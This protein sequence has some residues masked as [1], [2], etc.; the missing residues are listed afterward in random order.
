VESPVL[1]GGTH[2]AIRDWQ[3]KG[4]FTAEGAEFKTQRNAERTGVFLGDLSFTSAPLRQ[5]L[6]FV[7]D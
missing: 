7:R 2:I 6:R 4:I 5:V 3:I 1:F